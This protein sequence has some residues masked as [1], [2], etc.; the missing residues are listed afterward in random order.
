MT[1][2]IHSPARALHS[3]MEHLCSLA[4]MGVSLLAVAAACAIDAGKSAHAQ[5]RLATALSG[6]GRHGRRRAIPSPTRRRVGPCACRPERGSAGLRHP[7]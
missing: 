7:G 2:R 4:C 5:M 6:A 3:M 1:Q